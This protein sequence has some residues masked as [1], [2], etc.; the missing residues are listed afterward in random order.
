MEM[1]LFKP[2]KRTVIECIVNIMEPLKARGSGGDQNRAKSKVNFN[3]R[4]CLLD[5]K[6]MP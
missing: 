6:L 2:S 4:L 3:A 5:L 1:Y